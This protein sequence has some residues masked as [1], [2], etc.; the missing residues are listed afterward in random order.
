M[1]SFALFA[2]CCAGSALGFA[3]VPKGTSFGAKSAPAKTSATALAAK[4]KALPFMESP[5]TLD[6]SMIGDFG[7]D[8]LGLTENIDLPYGAS[9]R[10]KARAREMADNV[11]RM[12][13][14][15][16]AFLLFQQEAA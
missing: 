15:V 10:E 8:P 6:G 1:K 16:R 2:V 4:S 7:F 14:F 3:P 13:G 11:F 12:L 5:A 9:E